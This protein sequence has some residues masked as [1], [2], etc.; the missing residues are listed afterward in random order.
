[1]IMINPLELPNYSHIKYQ[2]CNFFLGEY[3]FFSDGS[4]GSLIA[5]E[6]YPISMR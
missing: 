4:Y 6:K 3:I 2:I 5:F 1:M